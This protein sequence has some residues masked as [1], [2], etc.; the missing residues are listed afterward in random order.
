MTWHGMG[1]DVCC[2]V[3][4]MLM[5]H[6]HAHV[7]DA[8]D[9]RGRSC[10]AQCYEFGVGVERDPAAAHDIY[11][12]CQSAAYKAIGGE[13]ECMARL[14]CATPMSV[15][16]SEHAS[17]PRMFV[18]RLDH[19]FPCSM[20]MLDLYTTILARAHN[21]SYA[22]VHYEIGLALKDGIRDV[23]TG[24]I[25]QNPD[26]VTAFKVSACGMCLSMSMSYVHVTLLL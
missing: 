24:R 13:A 3:D 19:M 17:E 21:N 16:R 26:H 9:D 10:L 18:S 2:D 5:S 1:C 12:T 8:E 4:V 6:L 7:S 23:Q 15:T 20:L 25:I 22:D 11:K 14:A